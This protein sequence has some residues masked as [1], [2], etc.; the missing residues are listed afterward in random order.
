MG[1]QSR[2]IAQKAKDKQQQHHKK[3]KAVKTNLKRL[4]ERVQDKVEKLDKL[5][6]KNAN[7]SSEKEEKMKTAKQN[8]QPTASS[9]D[10]K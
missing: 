6:D 2:V 10:K 9:V 8:N 5:Y 7:Q 4:N 3:P 1:K